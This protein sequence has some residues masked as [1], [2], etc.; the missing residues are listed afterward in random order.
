MVWEH[1]KELGKVV[2][3]SQLLG[4]VTVL[5]D[6]NAHLGGWECQ[7]NIQGV[8]LQEMMERCE[9]SAVSEGCSPLVWDTHTAVE[10]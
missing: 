10:M 6:F 5:G 7:Q 1:L 2:S 8:L 4:P 9:L 3:E